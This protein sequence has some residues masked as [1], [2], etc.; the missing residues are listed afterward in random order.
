MF[1]RDEKT[2]ISP[3]CYFNQD[4]A[5]EIPIGIL[6]NDG[7]YCRVFWGRSK[8]RRRG[9]KRPGLLLPDCVGSANS[10]SVIMSHAAF[11]V[12]F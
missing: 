2:N 11:N 1:D 12:C 3:L 7:H 10:D 5:N 9:Q 6:E 4:F 8:G